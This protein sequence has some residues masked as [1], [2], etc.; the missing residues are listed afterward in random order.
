MTEPSALLPAFQPSFVIACRDSVNLFRG[1]VQNMISVVFFALASSIWVELSSGN[2]FLG[3]GV[4][5]FT[6]WMA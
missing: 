6:L 1:Y 5:E 3:E 4:Q 2:L